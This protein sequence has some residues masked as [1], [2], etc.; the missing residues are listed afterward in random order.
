LKELEKRV[1]KVKESGK[2][3]DLHNERF[4]QR[5]VED[6]KQSFKGILIEQDEEREKEIK[7]KDKEMQL[8][9]VELIERGRE[10][11]EGAILLLEGLRKQGKMRRNR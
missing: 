2:E 9:M 10:I 1:H 3:E 6:M 7:I 11:K 8:K 4:V 5:E